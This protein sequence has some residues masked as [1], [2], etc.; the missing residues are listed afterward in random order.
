MQM[1]RS[2][3]GLNLA[4]TQLKSMK[5]T[6]SVHTLVSLLDT[7][8]LSRAVVDEKILNDLKQSVIDTTI[9]PLLEMTKTAQGLLEQKSSDYYEL[10]FNQSH[11]TAVAQAL[12]EGIAVVETCVGKRQGQDADKKKKCTELKEFDL[13]FGSLCLED[14][15]KSLETF[16]DEN[17][18]SP[19]LE[20]CGKNALNLAVAHEPLRLACENATAEADA[21]AQVCVKL[22]D[23]F[24]KDYCKH[25]NAESGKCKKYR[26]A[27]KSTKEIF[28]NAYSQEMEN[29]AKRTE[30]YSALK[31]ALCLVDLMISENSMSDVAAKVSVCS[32][33][34]YNVTDVTVKHDRLK[35]KE[36]CSI[37][38]FADVEAKY[39]ALDIDSAGK[40]V[41]SDTATASFNKA[42]DNT[43]DVGQIV[44]T[45]D[46]A[47]WG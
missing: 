1:A 10:T 13:N 4:V 28:G 38:D 19:A 6:E 45:A 44:D 8:M 25:R 40:C 42:I 37:K 27:V 11:T 2:V 22:Y 14:Y 18:L 16:T 17:A 3:H 12:L 32:S 24:S 9:V 34:T 30:E 39:T 15:L 41:W 31:T 35:E 29:N 26:E 36:D 23:A 7:L 33:K 21:T 5:Q 43:P 47:G 20:E 46:D